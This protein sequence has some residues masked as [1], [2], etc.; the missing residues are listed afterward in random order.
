MASIIIKP[1]LTS[2]ARTYVFANFPITLSNVWVALSGPLSDP[3]LVLNSDH[4]I[5]NPSKADM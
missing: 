1:P 2:L 3:V 5:F 4:F